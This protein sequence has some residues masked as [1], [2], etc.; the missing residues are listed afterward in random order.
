MITTDTTTIKTSIN[1]NKSFEKD[2]RYIKK[3]I[4][5][6]FEKSCRLSHSECDMIFNFLYP[7]DF[8]RVC[9]TNVSPSLQLVEIDE[10]KYLL[11]K[12]HTIIPECY[13]YNYF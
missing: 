1:I 2:Y 12:Y 3:I 13:Y 11:K 6:C 10:I 5:K 9:N 4:T 7:C 8:V